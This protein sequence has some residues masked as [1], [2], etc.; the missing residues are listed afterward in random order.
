MTNPEDHLSKIIGLSFKRWSSIANL[1]NIAKI[2]L[3]QADPIVQKKSKNFV[4]VF[5][6][7]QDLRT[8]MVSDGEDPDELAEGLPEKITKSNKQRF[9]RSID[10]TSLIFGHSMLDY[11][12]FEYCKITYHLNQEYW[13]NKIQNQKISISDLQ[14]KSKDE[15]IEKKISEYF[16]S[17]ERESLVTKIDSIFAVCSPDANFDPLDDYKYDRSKILEIDRKRHDIIHSNKELEEIDINENDIYYFQFTDLY[18]FVML[19]E[20]FGL[21]INKYKMFK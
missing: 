1:R 18:L 8:E 20:T 14:K 3:E 17:F 11:S 5:L 12:T 10:A 4:D 19:K 15:I 7:S 21:E 6:S 9:E 13:L 16:E 2:G